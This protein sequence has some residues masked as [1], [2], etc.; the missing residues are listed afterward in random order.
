MNDPAAFLKLFATV[1]DMALADMERAA[2]RREKRQIAQWRRVFREH[3][4][5]RPE[6]TAPTRPNGP[7]YERLA[8]CCEAA[9]I[10][11]AEAGIQPDQV[12]QDVPRAYKKA[13]RRAHPDAG[14]S[15]ERF[16]RLNQAR[17]I[18]KEAGLSPL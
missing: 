6:P 3:S 2:P 17:D 18:L 11:A 8:A 1:A 10:I 9:T 5:P 4:Q 13:A 16:Q 14:G 7:G 12:L 15:A